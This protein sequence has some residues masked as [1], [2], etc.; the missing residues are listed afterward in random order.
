MNCDFNNRKRTCPVCG[1]KAKRLP[2]HRVC[3]PVPPKVWRPIAVGDLVERGLTRLG[4]TK[5]R[6]ERWTRTAGKPG[7]CGCD[8]RKKWLNDAG[9]RVQYA[10]IG[11]VKKAQAFYGLGPGKPG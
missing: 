1:Y 5:E 9:F 2:T 7:G 4:I 11:A 10:V 8:R 6:V 3:R